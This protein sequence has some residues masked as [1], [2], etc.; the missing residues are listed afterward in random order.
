M[1][2]T[3]TKKGNERRKKEKIKWKRDRTISRY[4]DREKQIN[5]QIDR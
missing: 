4:T 2:E 3:K 5:R 1:K